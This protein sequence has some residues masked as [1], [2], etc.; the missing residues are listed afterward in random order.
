MFLAKYEDLPIRF[1][2]GGWR[3]SIGVIEYPVNRFMIL[4]ALEDYQKG[5]HIPKM[6]D[7]FSKTVERGIQN[8]AK[9]S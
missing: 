8:W 3:F 4:Q 9:R 1:I 7:D 2:V 5:I 6:L